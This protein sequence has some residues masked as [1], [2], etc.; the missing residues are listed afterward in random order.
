MMK[1]ETFRTRKS[2]ERRHF[3]T[4]PGIKNWFLLI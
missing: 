2:G 3:E 4:N 1:R